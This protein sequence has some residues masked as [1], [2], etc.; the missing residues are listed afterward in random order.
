MNRKMTDPFLPPTRLLLGPG[1]SPVAPEVLAAMA[2]P[3]IGH[4][5]PAFIRLMDELKAMLQIVFN[6]K[7]DAT[8]TVAGPG[9]VGMDACVFGVALLLHAAGGF[10]PFADIHGRLSP[11]A[12][13]Q[14]FVVHQRHLHMEIN[15]VQQRSADALTIPLNDH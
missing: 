8:F 1:P 4:L 2:N 6:T 9:S 13:G 10:H 14:C 11:L 15:A 7:N 12:G 5:D 3:T